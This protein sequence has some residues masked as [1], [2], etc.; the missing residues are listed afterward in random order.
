MSSNSG[1]S[2]EIFFFIKSHLHFTSIKKP[3]AFRN[4]KRLLFTDNQKVS[5]HVSVLSCLPITGVLPS[6]VNN[7]GHHINI[8]QTEQNTRE[9][10]P[11][12]HYSTTWLWSLLM[13]V[14]GGFTQKKNSLVSEVSSKKTKNGNVAMWTLPT[15]S[16]LMTH[17]WITWFKS[18][19]ARTKVWSGVVRSNTSVSGCQVKAITFIWHYNLKCTGN[20]CYGPMKN[21]IW[22]YWLSCSERGLKNEFVVNLWIK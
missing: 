3:K 8:N 18:K 17:W 10:G 6:L 5:M 13:L 14:L 16:N 21:H 7:H 15:K 4:F 22:Q 19:L 9:H 2:L 12:H 11:T 20:R 1:M